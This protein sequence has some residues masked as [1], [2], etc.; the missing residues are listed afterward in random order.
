[1]GI[2]APLHRGR[3]RFCLHT[4]VD[5]SGGGDGGRESESASRPSFGRRFRDLPEW[6]RESCISTA[7][8]VGGSGGVGGGDTAVVVAAVVATA[9]TALDGI[10]RDR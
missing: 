1:M 7:T 6:S 4:A 10:A 5:C 8:E 9:V 3:R 2:P